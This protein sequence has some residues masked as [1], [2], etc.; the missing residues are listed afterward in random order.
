[1]NA[2]RRHYERFASVC[3]RGGIPFDT[4]PDADFFSRIDIRQIP[5]MSDVASAQTSGGMSNVGTQKRHA[6]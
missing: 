2:L 5:V 1:M 3:S 6:N 4:P